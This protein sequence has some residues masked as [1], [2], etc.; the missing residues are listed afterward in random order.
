MSHGIILRT[1]WLL[2]LTIECQDTNTLKIQHQYNYVYLTEILMDIRKV[3][4]I[5]L[6][7]N[8]RIVL[9]CNIHYIELHCVRSRKGN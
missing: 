1:A 9:H 8:F 3:Y 2:N 4:Y 7:C 5:V 6:N